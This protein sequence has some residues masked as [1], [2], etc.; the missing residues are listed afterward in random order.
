MRKIRFGISMPA[1]KLPKL[2]SADPSRANDEFADSHY[3]CSGCVVS[4]IT[5]PVFLDLGR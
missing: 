1:L 3:G 5:G 4:G 2:A